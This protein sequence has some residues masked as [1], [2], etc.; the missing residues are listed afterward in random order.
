[1]SELPF[2]AGDVALDFVNTAELRGDPLAGDALRTPGDLVQWGR[3]YGL[4]ASDAD[5]ADDAELRKALQ[6]RELL[7]RLFAAHVNGKPPADA[8]LAA[9]AA[10]V[11]AAHA[12]ARLVVRDDGRLRWAWDPTRPAT[13]RNTAAAAA[14]ELLRGDRLDR[15]KQCPGEHCGWLF[16][17]ATKR[18]NR[19]WCSMSECGQ[20]AKTARRRRRRA[21]S[22]R[23]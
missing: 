6:T 7:Y 4:L 13:I 21:P 9:L 11:A 2:V 5:D 20:E 23:S 8:D 22:Q 16:I 3:R 19:R 15:L 14:T 10:A 12:A 18:G 1:M 17:D